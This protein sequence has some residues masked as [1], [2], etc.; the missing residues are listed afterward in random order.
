[1][2][3][4]E[5]LGALSHKASEPAV[6]EPHS[7]ARRNWWGI[8][9]AAYC[10]GGWR[11]LSAD[12]THCPGRFAACWWLISGMWWTGCQGWSRHLLTPAVL[13]FRY[14]QYF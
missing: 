8:A 6:S 14:H 3:A 11:S 2:A 13:P 4:E 12:P 1:M 7:S 9:V 5:G 10:W